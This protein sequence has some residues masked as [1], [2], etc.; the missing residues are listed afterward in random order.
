M[1]RFNLALYTH[2]NT[3]TLD[4]TYYISILSCIKLAW[5][6]LEKM[7][8]KLCEQNLIN[9]IDK[10]EDEEEC[11]QDGY[12]MQGTKEKR[13]IIDFAVHQETGWDEI[14]IVYLL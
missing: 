9:K 1:Q 5:N 4:Q 13:E 3:Y 7:P 14:E 11:E 10:A 12:S 6:S 2:T 8:S